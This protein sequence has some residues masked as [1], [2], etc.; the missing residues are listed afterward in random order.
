MTK[1]LIRELEDG[2]LILIFPT[3]AAL[4]G[5]PDG[6]IRIVGFWKIGKNQFQYGGVDP[7]L[8]DL[9]EPDLDIPFQYEQYMDLT[10]AYQEHFS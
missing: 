6:K 7:D 3:I 8:V 10:N 4:G 5:I 9:P 2:K 1:R